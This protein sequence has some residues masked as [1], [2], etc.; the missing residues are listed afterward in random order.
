[1]AFVETDLDLNSISTELTFI[2]NKAKYNK[3]DDGTYSAVVGNLW[4]NKLTLKDIAILQKNA[5]KKLKVEEKVSARGTRY[6]VLPIL[7][8]DKEEE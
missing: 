5:S 8:K 4:I 3:K 2:P 7:N 6:Y 1:M